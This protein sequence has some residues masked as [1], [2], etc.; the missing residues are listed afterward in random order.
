MKRAA[1][2]PPELIHAYEHCAKIAQTHY[3]NF[4]VG[5]WFLPRGLRSH[6]Y[7]IYAFCRQTDDLGD[8][9]N[10]D[11]H[12]L[13]NDWEN[14]LREYLTSIPS[15][16]DLILAAVA[17]T[18]DRFD[19]PFNLFYKLIEANRMDQGNVRFNTYSNLLNYCDHSA[20]PVGRMVLATL[21][22]QN[23]DSQ[24]LSDSTCTALQL[25]N[26][27]QDIRRDFSMDRIYI[28][29]S[30]MDLFGYTEHELSLGV[31]TEQFRNLMAYELDRT[32]LLFDDGLPL[33]DQLNGRIKLDITLFSKGGISIINAIRR[34]NYDVLSERPI[35][36]K[37]RKLWLMITSSCRLAITGNP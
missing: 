10:G 12:S 3:E 16:P 1:P 24:L 20:N 21:G 33:I 18:I 22:I 27:W 23:E 34:M 8:E 4:T 36:S 26:F 6:F 31:V 30:D 17:D 2:R 37:K 35:L 19:I 15:D 11:R 29:K 13:L 5:S 28:P 9:S 25:T 7:A 32:Q 14:N